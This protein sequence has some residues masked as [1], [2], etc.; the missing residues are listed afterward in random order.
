MQ[1]FAHVMHIQYEVTC[2]TQVLGH[3]D[4]ELGYPDQELDHPNQEPGHPSL[5]KFR[6][7][8]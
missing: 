7:Q 6:N 1:T 5:E 4:Q 8:I 2:Y 3:P